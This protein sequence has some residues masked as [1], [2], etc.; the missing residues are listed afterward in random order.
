MADAGDRAEAQDHLLID[1][2]HRDQQ[3][4]RPQERRAVSLARLAV[5]R[6][7]ARIIVAGHHDEAGAD[8]GEQRGEAVL[9]GFARGDVA[10]KDCAEGGV[11]VADV[12]VVEDS[13]A[14]VVRIHTDGHDLPPCRTGAGGEP[15][16]LWA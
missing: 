14:G 16:A 1:V 12:R 10:V 9:E 2:E 7:G 8:D 3:R 15:S 5:G 13:G 6:E 4:E 11:D